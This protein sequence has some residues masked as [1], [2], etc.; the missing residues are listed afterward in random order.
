MGAPASRNTA[1]EAPGDCQLAP[2]VR[3]AN[4]DQGT[5]AAATGATVAGECWVL[6]AGAAMTAP[7]SLARR[8][9]AVQLSVASPLC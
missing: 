7:G 3:P 5:V 2:P 9:L 6:L 1:R 4:C 8:L